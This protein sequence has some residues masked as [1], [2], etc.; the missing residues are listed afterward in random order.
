MVLNKL[1]GGEGVIR[2]HNS[3]SKQFKYQVSSNNK[4]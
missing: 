1:Q 2:F 3:S 4:N